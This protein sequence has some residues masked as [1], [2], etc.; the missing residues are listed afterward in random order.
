MYTLSTA[1]RAAGQT[2]AVRT[3]MYKALRYLWVGLALVLAP[4]A[5]EG[6]QTAPGPKPMGPDPRREIFSDMDG[7]VQFLLRNRVVL[8]LT[9]DQVTRLQ[10]IDREMEERN[11][12]FV[13]Q[14]LQIRR[15][16]PRRVRESQMT[17]AQLEA[18]RAQ[19]RA[20]QPLLEQIRENNHVA[21]RGVGNVLTEPQKTRLREILSAE[22]DDDG[23][24]DS[25]RRSDDRRD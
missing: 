13:M 1:A 2:T 17:P 6:Q 19:L 7:P 14:L 21:M 18:Y 22:R 11:R 15:Q 5:L 12:P 25:R 23:G 9:T 3:P 4:L 24:R 8:S 20:A 16:I 10:E